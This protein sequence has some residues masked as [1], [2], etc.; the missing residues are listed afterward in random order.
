MEPEP[1]KLERPRS[2]VLLLRREGILQS[3]LEEN[4][5]LKP[6]AQTRWTLRYKSLKA[7][8]GPLVGP[9]GDRQGQE[10]CDC[11]AATAAGYAHQ[12]R[13]MEVFFGV[14]LAKDLFEMTDKVAVP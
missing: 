7:I 14:I 3:F 4:T 5:S 12:M 1:R 13:K 9:E 6:I 11:P 2:V 10:N 8:C